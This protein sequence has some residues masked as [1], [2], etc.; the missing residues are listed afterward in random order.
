VYSADGEIIDSFHRK[1]R[2]IVPFNKF[3]DHLV[4]ALLATEDRK[5]FDHW[6][7]NIYAFFRAVLVSIVQFDIVRGTSTVTMQLSRN[8]YFGLERTYSRKIKE[9]LTNQQHLIYILI[10]QFYLHTIFYQF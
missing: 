6:G 1:N 10:Y 8:L 4:K 3:P 9:I 5:F 7:V 2:T